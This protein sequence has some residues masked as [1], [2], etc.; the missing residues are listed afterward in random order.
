MTQ[1]KP[2]PERK[3][4]RKPWRFVMRAVLSVVGIVVLLTCIAVAALQTG[5]AK[6]WLARKVETT[7]A[8][9]G[10]PALKIGSIEGFLPFTAIVRDISLSDD[11]GRL[12]EIARLRTI[13]SALAL[14]DRE[15]VLSGID[16]SGVVIHRLPKSSGESGK[17]EP[18]AWP[19]LPSLPVSVTV[20]RLNIADARIGKALVGRALMLNLEGGASLAAGGE[21]LRLQM[22]AIWDKGNGNAKFTGDYAPRRSRL[23]IEARLGER[24]NGLLPALAGLPDRPAYTVSVNGAGPLK[25]WRARLKA[26]VSETA[27]VPPEVVPLTG[28]NVTLGGEV[29]LH[30][31]TAFHFDKFT[32]SAGKVTITAKGALR[33]GFSRIDAEV[34][35]DIAELGP[36]SKAAGIELAGRISGV[37]KV[38]GSVEKPRVEI[39]LAG[40]KLAAAGYKPTLLKIAVILPELPE[41]IAGN[42]TI[43]AAAKGVTVRLAS[44]FA[45]TDPTTL[46]LKGIDA[47]AK[48]LKLA[49]DLTVALAAGTADGALQLTA[50]DIGPAARLAGV[51]AAGALNAKVVLRVENGKQ[52]AS[53]N[54]RGA[55]LRV[56]QKGQSLAI[57]GLAVTGRTADIKAAPS[58]KASVT[59]LGFRTAGLSLSRLKATVDGAM[60]QGKFTIDGAGQANKPFQIA[61]SG[62]YEISGE[63][64][65]LRLAALRGQYGTLPFAAAGPFAVTRKGEALTLTPVTLRID[66]HPITARAAVSPT[67]V[68]IRAAARGIPAKML[69][70]VEG[71][72]AMDGTISVSMEISGPAK[73][74][75]GTFAF[76]ARGLSPAGAGKND[77]PALNVKGGGKIGGGALTLTSRITGIGSAPLTA[78]GK[79]P[80]IL[81]FAP[82]KADLPATRP[83]MAKLRGTTELAAL[84]AFVPIGESR[85]SGRG[86]V[87]IDVAGTLATPRVTG[88]A[89]ITGGGFESITTGSILAG[90]EM[91]ASSDGKSIRIQRLT[92]ND[93][94]GGRMSVTGRVNLAGGKV[95]AIEAALE[96]TRF[97]VVRLDEATVQ[98]SGRAKLTGTPARPSVRGRLTVNKAEIAVPKDVSQGAETIEVE[99]IDANGKRRVVKRRAAKTKPKSFPVALDIAVSLPGQVFVRGRGLESE[100]KGNLKVGGTTAAPQIDGK[101]EVVRGQIALLGKRF[102]IKSGTV[103][104]AGGELADPDIDFLAETKAN[105]LVAEVRATGTAQKPTFTLS[106]QPS[107]PQDEILSRLLFNKEAGNLTVFQAVQLASA[108]A[109]LAGKGGGGLTDRLR[110]AAG[111]ATLDFDGGDGG[112][113]GPN[114]RVGKYIGD[115]VYLSI[116]QGKTLDSS[117]VGVKVDITPSVAVESTIDQKGSPDIGITYRYDY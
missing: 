88:T 38:T 107:L 12:I 57:A 48:G 34:G 103:G 97:R 77:V 46:T 45:L 85:I 7:V 40:Q 96:L 117:K 24:K 75:R 35:Y 2:E 104:F 56:K 65:A 61:S 29:R 73:A 114:V 15:V 70:H 60:K 11:E 16:V 17:S 14:L 112:K 23:S 20:S 102:V 89:A 44:A 115:K 95:G 58:G 113:S 8:A 93:G 39:T 27:L 4:R 67:S 32:V 91:R 90:L 54:A 26:T 79:L 22:K 110:T 51:E 105:Q 53:L 64:A 82:F 49:G 86:Q 43:D 100:W 74:P 69:R 71:A 94:S 108:A 3:Q 21:G 76:E 106:S 42:I 62:T 37:A 36:L 72:P 68:D 92:A 31:L 84:Q 78:Q 55:A 101:L 25:S 99:F 1:A 59:V 52:A 63:A 47:N 83:I 41:R 13:L 19:E 87:A 30:E 98:M 66:G 10:G 18:F 116:Q 81:S 50:G 5:T 109:E 80:F 28:R 33:D 9:G 6:R 111:L